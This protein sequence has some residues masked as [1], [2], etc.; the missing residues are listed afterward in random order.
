MRS[1]SSEGLSAANTAKD[2]ADFQLRF[3]DIASNHEHGQGKFEI[4]T[5]EQF[6]KELSE[7]S[8][9]VP[10]RSRKNLRHTENFFEVNLLTTQHENILE[11]LSGKLLQ[12]KDL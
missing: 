2:P 6:F 1:T 10:L 8:Y 7:L 4:F 9:S 11:K 3:K 5:P 12:Q